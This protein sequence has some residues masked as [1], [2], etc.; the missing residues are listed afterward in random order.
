[1]AE[2]SVEV[3]DIEKHQRS[4]DHVDTMVARVQGMGG[5]INNEMFTFQN[6]D[7][8]DAGMGVY[9]TRDIKQGEL[10][11][12]VPFSECLSP[13]KVMKCPTLAHIFEEQQGL[14]D[15]P[16]EVLAIGIMYAVISQDT[17]CGWLDYVKAC[18]IEAEMNTTIYWTDAELEELNGTTVY[19]LTAMMKRQ[20]A[21]DWESVHVALKQVYPEL[22]GNTTLRLYKWALSMVYSRAVGMHRNGSYARVLVPVLDMANMLTTSDAGE[23]FHY[24]AAR[25]VVQLISARNVN[26]GNE[27]F[28][29]VG[30]YCNAKLAYTYGYVLYNQEHRAVDLFPSPPS[31]NSPHASLK[32]KM[33]NDQPLTAEQNYDFTGTL[34]TGWI[35]PNLLATVRVLQASGEE[36]SALLRGHPFIYNMVGPANEKRTYDSLRDLLLNKLNVDKA[37]EDRA[38]LGKLLLDGVSHSNRTVMALMIQVEE[39]ETVQSCIVLLDQCTAKLEELGED[40]VSPDSRGTPSVQSVQSVD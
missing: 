22:L 38:R 23:T 14:K 20:I 1:M 35:S 8:P 24:D 37:E 17:T 31:P 30:Q 33:L 40:Y 34:R 6:S 3:E 12:E 26:A 28:S 27:C 2:F 19:H 4:L 16:D 32:Q 15:F 7:T 36:L 25:D 18:P 21:A 9:A 29:T 13:E 10:L 39:R 5:K 11:M